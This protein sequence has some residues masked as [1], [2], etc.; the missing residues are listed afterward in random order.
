[1]HHFSG[2]Y[3]WRIWS[4]KI[5]KPRKEVVKYRKLTKEIPQSE[6]RYLKFSC[7]LSLWLLSILGSSG[8]C[9]NPISE[10]HVL[11]P[12]QLRVLIPPQE[13][14]CC[15]L[16]LRSRGWS[17]WAS[18]FS[19]RPPYPHKL[20]PARGPESRTRG[21]LIGL[22][23]NHTVNPVPSAHSRPGSLTA[24]SKDSHNLW[25]EPNPNSDQQTYF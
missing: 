12:D 2:N 19:P 6:G 14:F 23:S 15:H 25:R 17:L 11:L 18:P 4:T 1:M 8:F 9:V 20:L 21:P 13:V 24:S 3:Y 16:S 22:S 5:H 10:F 7:V